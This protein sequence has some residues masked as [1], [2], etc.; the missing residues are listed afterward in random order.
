MGHKILK[1]L[2]VSICSNAVISV[3]FLDLVRRNERSREG[4]L[5]FLSN[6]SH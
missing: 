5:G 4:E 1:K 3:F 6:L 2:F